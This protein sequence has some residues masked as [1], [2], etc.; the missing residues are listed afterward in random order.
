M[1]LFRA[2]R[3]LKAG[4]ALAAALLLTADAAG[5]HTGHSATFSASPTTANAYASTSSSITFGAF[6]ADTMEIDLEAGMKLAHDD[7]HGTEV[8]PNPNDEETIGSGTAYANWLIGFFCSKGDQTLTV[9]WEED[10][11]GAPTSTTAGGTVVAHYQMANSIG[12]TEN[13]WVVEQS[14]ANDDYK[15]WVDLNQ[16]FTCATQPTNASASISTNGTTASGGHPYQNPGT[17]GCYT[18]TTRFWDVSGT[19]HSGDA[20][21]A[22]AGGSCP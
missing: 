9:T 8:T 7:Q 5:A 14:D 17:A 6:E 16:S 10:M 13:I 22:L 19:Q 1:K 20:S 3:G 4:L 12:F 21:Q 18:V 11:T 15:M 2:R